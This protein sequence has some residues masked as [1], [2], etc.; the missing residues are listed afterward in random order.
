[1]SLF[2]DIVKEITYESLL[3]EDKRT[4]QAKERCLM[5]IAK[6]FNK[7]FYKINSGEDLFF[8]EGKFKKFMDKF[9]HAPEVRKSQIMRLAPL[10]CRLAFDAGFGSDAPDYKII[11]R[12]CDIIKYLYDMVKAGSIK[13]D[14]INI[15][16]TTFEELDNTF[17]RAIDELRSKK[18]ENNNTQ[19]EINN[20]YEII[21]PIDYETANEYGN[22]SCPDSKLCYTQKKL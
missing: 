12:L 14:N 10:F 4:N 18:S 6:Y 19:Y 2:K 3:N 13:T 7:N 16:T 11:D 8:L 20:D 22:Y 5:I 21:G 15:D 9:Y 1:M 17:G